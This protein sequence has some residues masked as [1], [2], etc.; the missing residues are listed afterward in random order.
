M[1][2]TGYTG[3][4]KERFYL[5]LAGGARRRVG[6]CRNREMAA[7]RHADDGLGEGR[8]SEPAKGADAARARGDLS[9][10]T[11]VVLF[12][13]VGRGPRLGREGEDQRL[14]RSFRA[15]SPWSGDQRLLVRE[16]GSPRPHRR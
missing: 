1:S 9:L 8:V 7:S 10:A 2:P 13:D 5:G 12:A 4:G 3:A 16:E 15:P 14:A 11:G 6:G